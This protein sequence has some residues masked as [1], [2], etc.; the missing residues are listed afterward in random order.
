MVTINVW[1]L[2]G[3]VTEVFQELTTLYSAENPNVHFNISAQE[4]QILKDFTASALAA[5]TED[6]DL[7]WF[8]ADGLGKSFAKEGYLLELSKYYDQYGWWDLQPAGLKKDMTVSGHGDFFLSTDWVSYPIM[9]YN[10]EIFKEANTIP[11][12][13]LEDFFSVGKKIKEAG[14]DVWAVGNKNQWTLEL[15]LDGLYSRFLSYEDFNQFADWFVDPDKSIESAEIM[16]S[17]GVVDTFSFI[18]RMKKEGLFN[19]SINALDDGEGRLLFTDGKAAIYQSGTWAAN[20]IKKEAP[21]IDLGYFVLPEH[22][23][24]STIKLYPYNAICVPANI[25]EEKLPVV[26]DFMNSILSKEYALS[27]FKTGMIATN[28]SITADEIAKVADPLIGSI[29][30][31]VNNLGVSRGVGGSWDPLMKNAQIQACQE[32]AEGTMTP[33]EAAQYLYDA[34]IEAADF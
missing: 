30:E 31:D 32:V 18:A 1:T 19:A 29:V 20:M 25:S 28:S 21:D 7:L 16:R 27:I 12:A 3:P 24:L 8:W 15:L 13:T 26:I 14:Y 2:A 22:N 11:P 4:T 10:K 5:G 9:Y 6:L 34:A 33:E 17:Q 23:E